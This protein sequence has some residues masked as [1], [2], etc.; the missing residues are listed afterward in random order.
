MKVSKISSRKREENVTETKTEQLRILVSFW[1][2][3]G[4]LLATFWGPKAVQNSMP[5]FGRFFRAW[6]WSGATSARLQRDFGGGISSADPPQGGAFSR[7]EG[8]YNDRRN[9][10]TRSNTPW[11]RGLAIFC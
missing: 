8:Y 4:M 2:D 1:S 3:F 11:A 10:N 5:F 6:A 9:A 7:A